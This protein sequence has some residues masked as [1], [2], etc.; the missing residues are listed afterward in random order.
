MSHTTLITFF[1]SYIHVNNNYLI[2]IMCTFVATDVI[3][4]EVRVYNVSANESMFNLGAQQIWEKSP[5]QR[6]PVIRTP[7]TRVPGGLCVITFW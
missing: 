7:N 1:L 6:E 2:V 3:P 4:R 5:L